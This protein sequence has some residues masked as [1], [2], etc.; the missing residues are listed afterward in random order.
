MKK[1]P[2]KKTCSKC[3]RK[4]YDNRSCIKREESNN[5][6]YNVVNEKKIYK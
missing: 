5:V 3:G 1:Q 4:H 2:I 6:I